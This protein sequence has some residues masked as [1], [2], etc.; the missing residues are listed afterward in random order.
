MVYY[1]LVAFEVLLGTVCGMA[2]DQISIK[3]RKQEKEESFRS[4]FLVYSASYGLLNAII[5]YSGA[6]DFADYTL[7]VIVN[8]IWA[9]SLVSSY[10]TAKPPKGK[11]EN[12]KTG[13]KTGLSNRFYSWVGSHAKTYSNAL[14]DY[15][16]PEI[17][18]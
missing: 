10:F 8:S 11:T 17:K 3:L 16:I 7:P 14:E 6:F 15:K 4:K 5:Y 18:T 9:G 1:D 2:V 12:E 13:V